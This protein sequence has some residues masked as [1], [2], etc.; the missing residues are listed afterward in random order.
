M[1]KLIIKELKLA[2]SPLTY[3]FVSFAFLTLAPGYPI[4]MATFFVCFGIFHSFQMARESNDIL[5]STLLPIKKE[6]VVKSKFLVCILFQ[7]VGFVIMFV[8]T[9]LRMTMMSEE[10]VYLYNP[11]MNAN[12]FFLACA[13]MIFAVFNGVF[14]RGFFR[15]AYYYT[16]PFIL[17]LVASLLIIGAGETLF[18]IPGLE[19]LNSGFGDDFYI[20]LI[21]FFFAVLL[22]CGITFLSYRS[23]QSRFENIDL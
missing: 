3:L 11:M 2:T 7:M 8:L 15:T 19:F 22:Y 16:K 20:Q 18:H 10:G 21:I 9:L 1:N 6:D 13:L 12:F 14:V 17:F 4:L 5:Y 23:S